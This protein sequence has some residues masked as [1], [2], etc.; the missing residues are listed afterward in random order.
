MF[1]LTIQHIACTKIFLCLLSDVVIECLGA[2]EVCGA[3]V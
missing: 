1:S 3:V 2:V